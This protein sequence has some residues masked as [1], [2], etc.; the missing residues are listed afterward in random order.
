MRKV[1]LSVAAAAVFAASAAA[2][3]IPGGM[4]SASLAGRSNL[5]SD[6][7]GLGYSAPE[8]VGST[9]DVGDEQRN[10][11]NVDAIAFGV[12]Q[13]NPISGDIKITETGPNLVY[14]PKSLKAVVYDLNVLSVTNGTPAPGDG[15]LHNIFK[16]AGTRYTD[17]VTG[18]GTDG[19]WTDAAPS[20]IGLA[21]TAAGY[22]GILIIYEDATPA[23]PV[24]PF[25]PG[26][27]AWN[28]PGQPG[29]VLAPIAGSMTDSDYYPGITDAGSV[30]LV[31]VLTPLPVSAFDWPVGAPAGTVLVEKGFTIDSDGTVDASGIGFANVIGG[32]FASAVQSDFFGPGRDIRLDFDIDGNFFAT[33]DGWQVQSDDPAQFAAIPEPA[34]MSLLGLAFAGIAAYRRRQK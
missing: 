19:F 12:K 4:Y 5:F 13:V 20:S 32:S 25:A 26:A 16:T 3:S 29:H 21:S 22:G 17:A 2:L 23:V 34:T 6:P 7:L 11:V 24:N 28:E 30:F 31:A 15:L 14:T 27:I 9:V 33:V 8:G 18:T 10:A 1:L